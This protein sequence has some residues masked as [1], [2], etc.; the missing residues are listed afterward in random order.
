MLKHSLL[1]ILLLFFFLLAYSQT[2]KP[3]I[4]SM[5]KD[6]KSIPA[7]Y[8]TGYKYRKTNKSRF[9][10]LD[11]A[12][13]CVAKLDTNAIITLMNYLSD[14]IATSIAN[15]CLGGYFTYGQL[16]FFLINDIEPIPYFTV[17]KSQWD[18]LG[19]CGTLPYG[20]LYYLKSKG[21]EFENEYQVYFRSQARQDW[22]SRIRPFK[23]D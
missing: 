17:T 3:D 22:I 10:G 13:V 12:Y 8:T 21:Q 5:M 9:D 14:T 18:V 23:K 6:V 1:L 2:E 11:S 7:W 16:A 4:L 15:T 19:E 20:F